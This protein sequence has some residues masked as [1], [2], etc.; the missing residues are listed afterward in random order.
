MKIAIPDMISNSYFPVLAAAELGFFRQEGL[1][2][3]VELMSPADR[4]YAAMQEGSVDFVGAEA[5]A[6][7]ATFPNGKA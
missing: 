1:D 6:A 7:L 4:A 3:S 5:H 2:V